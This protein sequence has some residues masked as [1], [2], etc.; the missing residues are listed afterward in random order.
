MNDRNSRRLEFLTDQIE[1]MAGSPSEVRS[2]L[3]TRDAA[4]SS[5][6]HQRR[7]EVTKRTFA[8]EG[9]TVDQLIGG[10]RSGDVTV[11]GK[12]IATFDVKGE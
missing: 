12:V 5:W 10:Q 3:L 9:F 11:R 1:V 7:L 2:K 6:Y 4:G 8:P